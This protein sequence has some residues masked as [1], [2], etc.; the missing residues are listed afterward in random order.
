V[1]FQPNFTGVIS[2]IP[3]CAHHRHILP[4]CTKWPSELYIE[5]SCPAF[6]G[7]ASAWITMKL[8]MSDHSLGDM[9]FDKNPSSYYF[10]TEISMLI[11]L[12]RILEIKAENCKGVK[13]FY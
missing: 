2:T 8:H 12:T 11:G 4:R 3:S 5:K 9:F 10:T 6:T 7:Q 13:Q 1:G